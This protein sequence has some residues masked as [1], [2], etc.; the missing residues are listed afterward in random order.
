M[1]RGSW[2]SLTDQIYRRSRSGVIRTETLNLFDLDNRTIY[3]RCLPG[4]P[5]R[6]LLPGVILLQNANPVREQQIAGALLYGGPEALIT[7]L[8]AC[9]RHGLRAARLPPDD[10]I[11][12]LIPAGSKHLSS[13][14]VTVER[15]FRMPEAII[16]GGV[17]LAPLV[18]ATT[19]AARR[20]CRED[21]VAKLIIEAIQ[22]GHCNPS[23][24]SKE[25]EVG[26]TRGT[27]IPRRILRQA[28]DLRSVAE[29]HAKKIS[30]QLSKPPT[31]WNC[32]VRGPR[33]E[34]IG[35]PDGW[36][37]EVAMAWEID[38]LEH[39]FRPDDYARTLRRNSRYAEFGI[40][41]VQT[42]PSRLE[43][44]PDGVLAEL[45]AAYAAAAARPRPA[46]HIEVPEE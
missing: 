11:H 44:D 34:Y 12:V 2:A 4:G 5:W 27:A 10:G 26:T 7:G 39:H 43:T 22:F 17:P 32:V 25:L 14:F 20:M 19:D 30:S 6:K 33:G 37:D 9:R 15:T 1:K 21:P 28:V 16:R 18:R 36:C 45:R 41:F 40:T 8:E 3:R 24:L 23:A 35:R 38:S 46:V 42:I 31:H 29:L 13:G